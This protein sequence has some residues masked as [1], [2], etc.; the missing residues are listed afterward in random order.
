MA[1][2]LPG[3]TDKSGSITTGGVAQTLAVANGDRVELT[4][5]NISSEDMWI[6]ETGGTAAANTAGSFKVTAG[7]TFRIST[8]MKVSIIAATTGSKFTA[9]EA[10]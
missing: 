2:R 5:Q 10:S 4:G 3:G 6:N 8:C 1:N 7:N 9:T